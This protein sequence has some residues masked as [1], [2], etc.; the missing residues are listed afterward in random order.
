[1]VGARKRRQKLV[2]QVWDTGIGIPRDELDNIFAEFKQL[3][4]PQRDRNNGLGLGLAIVKR[5]CKLLGHTIDVKSDPGKGSVFS[6]TMQLSKRQVQNDESMILKLSDKLQGRKVLLIDD[7]EQV[8]QAMS[9]LLNKWG[10]EVTT[11]NSQ[12]EALD[13]ITQENFQPDVII[14]DFR[15]A[16][17]RNG[18]EAIKTIIAEQN[19]DIPSLL[20]TGDTAPDQINAINESGYKVLHKPVKPARLRIMLNALCK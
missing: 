7:E 8:N 20:I 1:V 17:N 9:V 15:L 6:V 12:Q 10:C 18:V 5:L 2:L 3:N 4:N 13:K 16:E 14:S 11:A 19:R